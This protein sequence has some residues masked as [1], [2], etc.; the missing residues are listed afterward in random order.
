MNSNMNNTQGKNARQYVQDV[1]SQLQSSI[2][3]LNQAISSVEKPENK[4][5]I[6]NTFNAV[7]NALN[8]VKDTLTIM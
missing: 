5:K 6:Q 7:N 4:Q 3:C 2:N 1:Q 8:S